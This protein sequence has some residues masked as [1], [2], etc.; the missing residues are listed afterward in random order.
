MSLSLGCEVT[1]CDAC[2]GL[3]ALVNVDK[4]RG[5]VGLTQGWVHIS[6]WGRIKNKRHVPVV[7]Q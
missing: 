4:L 1:T 2:G 5:I 7:D 6:R 3:V